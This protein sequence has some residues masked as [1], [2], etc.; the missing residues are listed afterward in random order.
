VRVIVVK[1]H[2]ASADPV[3]GGTR[4]A[5]ICQRIVAAGGD[6]DQMVDI[7]GGRAAMVMELGFAVQLILLRPPTL[8]LHGCGR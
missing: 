5:E 6:R 3:T 7:G 1:S 2:T 4:R 8:R